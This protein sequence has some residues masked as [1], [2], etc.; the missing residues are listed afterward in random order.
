MIKIGLLSDTHSHF[1]PKLKDLLKDLD[2][3]WHAGDIGDISVLGELKKIC[4][5]VKGVYG[6]IDGRDIR[7][8]FP[9]HLIFEVGGMKVWITHIGGYPGRYPPAIKAMMK[10]VKPEIFICGHSHI[11]KV[12]R[13]PLYD[14]M[15]V[16]NPGAAGTHGWHKVKT[17]LRFK[18]NNGKFLDLEVVELGKR[19]A[20]D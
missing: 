20:I 12:M 11:L 6:N 2:Q 5:I 1:D 8:E 19:G 15:I 18:I 7:N 3:I 4:P 13:D 10:T 17:L 14:N 16:L 9:E